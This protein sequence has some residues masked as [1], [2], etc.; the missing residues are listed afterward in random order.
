MQ[1]MC[2]EKG[3]LYIHGQGNECVTKSA[4]VGKEK[5]QNICNLQFDLHAMNPKSAPPVKYF[6]N[7][8]LHYHLCFFLRQ[9]S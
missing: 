9:L 5:C 6:V 4:D 3:C 1:I 8:L 7:I 2:N